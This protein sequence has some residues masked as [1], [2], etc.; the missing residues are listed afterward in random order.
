ML[1]TVYLV[2]NKMKKIL[3]IVYPEM[4]DVE[5]TNV[6]VVFSFIKTI[7]TTCYHHSLKKITASNGV[8]EVNNIVN[9]INLSEFDA[10]YIPGGIGATKHLD[11]DEKLLKTINYFKV[12]NLY[13]FAICDTPNVLFKHGII[14][15]DEIYSS[16]PNPN[17]VMSENRSTAK[18]TV[19]N[20]L[21]TARSAGCALEFATVIV[22][23]FL[24]DNTLNELVHKRLFGS[25]IKD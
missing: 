2:L 5:Y 1:G 23:T 11:K 21:I 3:V 13:L 20:K 4:N 9:T 17:L 18:V 12:N 16:F 6:M 24:K 14:T 19:A 8:V 22:C 7:Q 25:E 15:K 10:V